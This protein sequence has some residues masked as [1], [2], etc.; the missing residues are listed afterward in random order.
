MTPNHS[1]LSSSTSVHTR[2]STTD[3]YDPEYECRIDTYSRLA[4][5][6]GPFFVGPIPVQG[7]LD[8]F[9]PPL[10]AASVPLFREGMFDPLI[11]SIE[12][13]SEPEKNGM[14]HL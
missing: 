9:L 11:A 8:F 5:E 14:I 3:R 13:H 6:M 12:R 7:F 1:L 10:S 2:S 4:D